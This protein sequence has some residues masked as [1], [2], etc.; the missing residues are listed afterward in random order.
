MSDSE[1]KDEETEI[2]GE[3]DGKRRHLILLACGSRQPDLIRHIGRVPIYTAHGNS[4]FM[5][6]FLMYL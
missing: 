3:T 2:L 5:M 4:Y 6:H 1:D